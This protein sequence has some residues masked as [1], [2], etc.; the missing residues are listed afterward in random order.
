MGS[1]PTPPS[2]NE[3]D[4]FATEIT[5]TV[6]EPP[7]RIEGNGRN[8]AKC[9]PLAT[10]IR[11]EEPSID[12]RT[13]A[14]CL[15]D[16]GSSPSLIDRATAESHGLKINKSVTISIQ[17]FG[18]DKCT[19]FC[20]VPIWIPD[21]DDKRKWIRADVEFHVLEHLAPKI[22]LG[23]DFLNDYGIDLI[24]TENVAHLGAYRDCLPRPSCHNCLFRASHQD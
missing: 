9:A 21:K 23:R 6:V 2:P 4:K 16:P 19:G 15:M 10:Q 22:L 14:R 11:L 13:T 24:M 8:Y 3:A 20:V 17:R 5:V 1:L 7:M 18:L 12:E